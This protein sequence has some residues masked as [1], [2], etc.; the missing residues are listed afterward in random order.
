MF[1]LNL[2][3]Q[4]QFPDDDVIITEVI[5]IKARHRDFD[6]I[7]T[8]N[9]SLD[10]TL[11]DWRLLDSSV[12]IVTL[13]TTFKVAA[14]RND[15]NMNTLRLWASLRPA[16][17]SVLFYTEGDDGSFL[18]NARSLG[19]LT[20]PTPKLREGIPVLKD[21]FK[22]V[23][24]HVTPKSAFIGYANSDVVFTED[25]NRTLSYISHI[26]WYRMNGQGLLLIGQRY[27][28]LIDTLKPIQGPIGIEQSNAL[29]ATH[30]NGTIFL[31]DYFITT[32][33]GFPFDSLPDFVVGKPGYDN[34]IVS[35]SLE[36]QIR[37][38]DCTKTIMALHQIRKYPNEDQ[39]WFTKNVCMNNDIVKPFAIYKGRTHC[40]AYLTDYF[41]DSVQ[42][43]KRV[44]LSKTCYREPSNS[45]EFYEHCRKLVLSKSIKMN[46]LLNKTATVGL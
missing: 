6:S 25:L 46:S 18:E 22:Y 33:T 24:D 39:G 8:I 19:W 20:Y 11:N 32:S 14:S 41:Q 16:V 2:Q 30:K 13:F 4:N 3:N 21:M 40:A 5:D 26:N 31:I 15:M 34:W 28:V 42:I 12:P 35:K 38:I 45:T 9:K 7:W 43:Y 44:S 37:V 23:I 29:R 10:S 1:I 17:R 36:W 27:D